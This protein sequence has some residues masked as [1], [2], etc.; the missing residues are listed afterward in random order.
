VPRRP[1]RDCF[2]PQ[3]G[4]I[5][6]HSVLPVGGTKPI[7]ANVRIIASTNLDLDKAVTERRFRQDLY[8]RLSVVN[9]DLPPLRDRPEDIPALIRYFIERFNPKLRRR[10][11]GVA[12]ETLRHLLQYRWKGNIRE[13]QNVLER[14]MILEDGDLITPMSLP[15]NLMQVRQPGAPM[16]PLKDAVRAFEHEYIRKVLE[17][18]AGD[19]QLA[20]EI[21]GV[22]VSSIY[23]RLQQ[24]EDQ[25]LHERTAEC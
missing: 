7:S 9:V 12:N 10:I 20:A 8:Y 14:A 18:T 21:L 1:E 22:S 3:A 2:A 23:R 4:A 6:D 5:E 13:L 15:S 25:G 24:P 11:R 17:T 16:S 19:K